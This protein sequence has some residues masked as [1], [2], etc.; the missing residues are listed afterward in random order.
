M[1]KIYICDTGVIT[2]DENNTPKNFR[3]D[4]E[5][6]N[7][8]VLLDEDS[9]IIYTKKGVSKTITG[10]KG[11][12][13][14]QFYED[15]FENPV[16]IVDSDDWKTNLENYR[17]REEEMKLKWAESKTEYGDRDTCAPKPVA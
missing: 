5:S 12:I 9:E 7:R 17:K 10:H 13:M 16:V 4:R 1:N 11:Q 8:I 3:S 14:V 15:T 6:I 2:I